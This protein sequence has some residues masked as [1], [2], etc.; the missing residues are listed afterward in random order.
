[1]VKKDNIIEENGVEWVLFNENNP[2][3]LTNDDSDFKCKTCDMSHKSKTGAIKHSTWKHNMNL[4][5]TPSNKTDSNNES[6]KPSVPDIV[7]D[8]VM[9]VNN[10]DDAKSASKITKDPEL[11]YMFYMMK[12]K[13][14][15][16]PEWTLHDFL[17]ESAYFYADQNGISW[18]FG[19]DLG[20][21]SDGVRRNAEI[22][23]ER[24]ENWIE[25][26]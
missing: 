4:D 16:D 19:Q 10:T 24:W 1:M 9:H 20:V 14:L 13:K 11:M 23:K 3:I 5:G 26:V 15:I 22:V 8:L 7:S 6:T 25:E 2:H 21:V 18:Y 12:A 17:R